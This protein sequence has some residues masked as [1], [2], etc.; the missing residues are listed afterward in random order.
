M[1]EGFRGASFV[2][3]NLLKW[4]DVEVSAILSDTSRLY[5]E[6]QNLEKC[7]FTALVS[8]ILSRVG[9]F[10]KTIVETYPW[11]TKDK[12]EYTT[13]FDNDDWVKHIDAFSMSEE[14]SDIDLQGLT[15]V[16][17]E[18]AYESLTQ[19]TE[20][21]VLYENDEGK[22]LRVKFLTG[23]SYWYFA[24]YHNENSKF[25]WVENYISELDKSIPNY[26]VVH[27][28]TYEQDKIK[29]KELDDYLKQKL[30]EQTLFSVDGFLHNFVPDNMK[31]NVIQGNWISIREDILKDVQKQWPI[32]VSATH[33]SEFSS[34][35]QCLSNSELSYRMGK[36]HFREAVRDAALACE[37]TL[38][39]L[40][41]IYKPKR[42]EEKM[43]FYDLQCSLKD[44]LIDKFGENVYN[45]LDY[46]REQ[47]NL[48]S[49]APPIEPEE[50]TTF[51]VI[52]RANIFHNLFM[53]W[54][55]EMKQ[56]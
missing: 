45:D 23:P 43:E 36:N 9:F 27:P 4:Y 2:F 6:T 26:I 35:I 37:S 29:F 41:D 44:I 30:G 55:K 14:M 46:I 42:I 53:K 28:K 21:K 32:L 33:S 16:E 51:Q 7:I 10:N 50:L 13:E 17:Y 25:T 24:T 47:R 49:H 1:T 54:L 20:W 19:S 5:K 12:T 15:D 48:A 22:N 40:Y 56:I 34:I 8:Y 38:S 52:S 39:L 3:G 31:K 11:D 18:L